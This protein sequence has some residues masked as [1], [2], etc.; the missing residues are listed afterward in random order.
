MAF[1]QGIQTLPVTFDV[2]V[3]SLNAVKKAAYKHVRTFTADIC[4]V[5]EEIRCLLNFEQPVTE[6]QG[7]RLVDEL[8]KEVLD[9]DLR[10][11]LK[12]ETESLRNV[13][14]AHA[15]SKTGLVDNEPVSGN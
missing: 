7:L 12:V 6:E 10:E 3:Y 13:I 2:K 5:D 4:V 11:T 8:K 15:F 14:L 9:Q 1:N